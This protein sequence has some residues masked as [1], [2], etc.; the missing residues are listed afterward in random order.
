MCEL[1]KTVLGK[2]QRSKRRN[3]T[4]KPRPGIIPGFFVAIDNVMDN[5]FLMVK[6]E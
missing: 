4:K 2:E 6:K 3:N 1:T 5:H